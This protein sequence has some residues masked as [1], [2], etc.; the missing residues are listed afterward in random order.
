[1][2]KAATSRASKAQ[3]SQE[4]HEAKETLEEKETSGTVRNEVQEN[5]E[6]RVN[7]QTPESGKQL[8]KTDI[9]QE[10]QESVQRLPNADISQETEEV[11]VN[12]ALETK[13]NDIAQETD[14]IT[15]S[16]SPKNPVPGSEELKGQEDFESDS[17]MLMAMREFLSRKDVYV[18]QC[19]MIY[20]DKSSFY[21][22]KT[23]THSQDNIFACGGCRKVFDSTLELH[24]HLQDTSCI[25]PQST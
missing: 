2:S 3:R 10:T 9:S 16:T 20:L 21:L 11:E 17:D 14:H 23:T 25:R 1:M 7:N 24:V 13:N 5:S 4:S 8:R 18:C 15:C 12:H 19:E 22:H 6:S